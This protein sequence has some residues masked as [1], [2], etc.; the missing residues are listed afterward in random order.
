M[1]DLNVSHLP[2]KQVVIFKGITG[3]PATSGN[4]SETVGADQSATVALLPNTVCRAACK[5]VAPEA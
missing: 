3:S 4:L 5:G 2:I 1:C